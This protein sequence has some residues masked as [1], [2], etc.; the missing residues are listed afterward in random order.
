MN[1]WVATKDIADKIKGREE[2]EFEFKN[3]KGC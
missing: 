1:K 3:S 2:L